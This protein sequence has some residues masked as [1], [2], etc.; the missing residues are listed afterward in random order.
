MIKVCDAIMGSGKTSAAINYMNRYGEEKH[1]IYCTPYIDETKRIASACPQLSFWMPRNDM[2]T[3]EFS[4]GKH[5]KA[6]LDERRNIAIS[7]KLFS[8]CDEEA[9]DLINQNGYTVIIDEAVEVF[10]ALEVSQSDINILVDSGW[11]KPSA[12][13]DS[14]FEYYEE[15][16]DK[17]Y[18]GGWYHELFLAA[19]SNR[20][21]KIHDNGIGDEIFW[22]WSLCKELFEI[23]GDVYILTYLFP[24]SFLRCF[25]DINHIPYQ[26]IHI[27][28]S[29]AG[30]Y[31]FSD[32]PTL[33]E[34]T[35]TLSSKIHICDNEKLNHIGNNKNA[36]SSSWTQREAKK[37]NGK[38]ENLRKCIDGF[39]RYHHSDIP[40]SQRLWSVF[41]SGVSKIRSK[42]FYNSHLVFNS[43]A[44][45]EYRDKTIL[46]YCVNIF[47]NP[48]IVYYMKKNG[49]DFDEDGYALSIM[50]QWIWRSAIRDG[51]EIWIYIPSKR[52]RTLLQNW[53]EAT[54]Q[55]YIHI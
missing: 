55:N 48:Y 30:E 22:M 31:C 38:I 35:A 18:Q 54:E 15:S 29:N 13:E 33:P 25:L 7:H 50:I 1:F 39:F 26:Y 3:Y 43:K 36:L 5:L 51:K 46:A 34:Y 8:M 32:K 11:L 6:L 28:R 53:I 49:V 23:K 40:A 17:Q 37:Q 2:K 19:K 45:N 4:K 44:S 12:S 14:E 24:H 47:C 42:G 52:M 41:N 20:L 21:V 10:N 27:S 16:A 9:I